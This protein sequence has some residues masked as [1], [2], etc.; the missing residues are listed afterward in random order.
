M[1]F[2]HTI[3]DQ[4]LINNLKIICHVIYIVNACTY[5]ILHTIMHFTYNIIS[6]KLLS[7][8]KWSI[9]FNTV[10]VISLKIN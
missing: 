10:W 3:Q 4:T 6:E 9:I 5:M 1:S 8:S 7:L 2:M